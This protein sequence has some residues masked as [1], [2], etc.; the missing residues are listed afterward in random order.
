MEVFI[1]YAT[2]V[3]GQLTDTIT[4][5]KTSFYSMEECKVYLK[6]NQTMIWGT[7]NAHLEKEYPNASVT[8]V[9]CSS[10]GAF[11]MRPNV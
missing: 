6:D 2:L 10:T 5:K 8:H 1:I 7:L 11:K 4:F 3:Y 9:G